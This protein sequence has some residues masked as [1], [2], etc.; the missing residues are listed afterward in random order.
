M[1][2]QFIPNL[3]STLQ[4]QQSQR[5]RQLGTRHRKLRAAA[6]MERSVGFTCEV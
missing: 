3:Y 5:T 6:V 4:R 2:H 1:K